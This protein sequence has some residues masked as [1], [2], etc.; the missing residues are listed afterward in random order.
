MPAEIDINGRTLRVRPPALL[1]GI[2][3]LA[4]LW[5]RAQSQPALQLCALGAVIGHHCPE[6]G[7]PR[8]H[9]HDLVSFGD[10]VVEELGLHAAPVAA[11][12]SALIVAAELLVESL[13][14]LPTREAVEEAADFSQ[15]QTEPRT[16]S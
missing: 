15:A 2:T 6:L 8:D 14:R 13:D 4:S 9:D 12:S 7:H 3:R 16:E 11:L 10:H 1:G 5:S